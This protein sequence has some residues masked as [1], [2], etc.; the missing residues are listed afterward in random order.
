MREIDRCI[1]ECERFIKRAESTENIR[2]ARQIVDEVYGAMAS[3]P[4]IKHGLRKF[5]MRVN[6]SEPYSD[7]EAALDI[8]VLA[9]KLRAYRDD[10]DRE[11][12]IAK[13]D[14]AQRGAT[15]I[16]QD[17]G[18]SSSTAI[19]TSSVTLTQ[20]LEALDRCNV[21]ENELRDIKAAISELEA[22]K[23]KS[24]ETVLDKTSKLLDLAKRAADTAKAVAPY[25]MMALQALA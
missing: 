2:G 1:R 9:G 14:A 20:T 21:T 5:Q 3:V 16:I 10:I 17:V 12:R 22:S 8:R 18:N 4:N 6:F 19:S 24:P 11:E 7:S 23:G 13:L 25:A 15:V